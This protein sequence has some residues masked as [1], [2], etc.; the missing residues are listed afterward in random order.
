MQD[1]VAILVTAV[2]F[3]ATFGLLRLIAA[4][5]PSADAPGEGP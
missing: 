5:D 1:L 4:L 3:A 2:L